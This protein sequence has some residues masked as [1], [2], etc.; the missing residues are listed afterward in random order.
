MNEKL[1]NNKIEHKSLYN[2]DFVYINIYISYTM[3]KISN[4]INFIRGLGKPKL[5]IEKNFTVI[6]NIDPIN[7]NYVKDLINLKLRPNIINKINE[8]QTVAYRYDDLK[9]K[10]CECCICY[11]SENEFAK[12][13]CAH[14]VCI[15]CYDEL[16]NKLFKNCPICNKSLQ[17][18]SMDKLFAI[19]VKIDKG[20]G[21]LYSPPIF[22]EEKNIWIENEI[23]MD[24]NTILTSLKNIGDEKYIIV[25]D[26]TNIME[27]I[28][29]YLPNGYIEIYKS[30]L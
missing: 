30:F 10:G 13:S 19:L 14:E 5:N 29:Q 25:L 9:N 28:S 23:C 2:N 11:D 22:N 16:L 20:I 12:L 21:I 7:S 26:S 3:A 8:L 27:I 4:V 15:D 24:K 18:I 17:I 1:Y 6:N